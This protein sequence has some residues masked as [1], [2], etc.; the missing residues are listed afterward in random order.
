MQSIRKIYYTGKYEINNI[1]TDSDNV[2]YD[3]K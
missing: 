2:N 3:K 1:I